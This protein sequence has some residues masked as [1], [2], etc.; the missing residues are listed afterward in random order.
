ML[1]WLVGRFPY[2]HPQLRSQLPEHDSVPTQRLSSLHQ[3]HSLF[4][5][6]GLTETWPRYHSKTTP[7]VACQHTLFRLES[8]LSQELRCIVLRVFRPRSWL[9]SCR[10]PSIRRK[11][12]SRSLERLLV[13]HILFAC[14]HRSIPCEICG[15][16]RAIVD[17]VLVPREKPP[18]T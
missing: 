6:H 14:W 3:R 16:L 8:P 9:V 13:L 12:H 2:P 11:P 5:P 18:P 4:R 1:P 17:V 10:L 7:S 15:I